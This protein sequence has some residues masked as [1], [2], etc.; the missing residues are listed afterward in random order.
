MQNV[1]WRA[2]KKNIDR[3]MK[4]AAKITLLGLLTLVVFTCW[5][6]AEIERRPFFSETTASVIAFIC[7]LIFYGALV[8]AIFIGI[9]SLFQAPSDQKDVPD[10]ERE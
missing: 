2:L 5:A 7:A 8:L 4:R 9:K 6:G 10:Q 1:L 3:G